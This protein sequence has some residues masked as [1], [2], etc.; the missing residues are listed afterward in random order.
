MEQQSTRGILVA[1]A[2]VLAAACGSESSDPQADANDVGAIAGAGGNDTTPTD[3]TA[4]PGP[5]APATGGTA[6]SPSVAPTSAPSTSSTFAGTCV[7]VTCTAPPLGTPGCCTAPGTG[8]PGNVLETAGRA[9]DMCGTDLGVFVPTLTGVCV[10][11]DQ[12]GD[13]DGACPTVSNGF[14]DE[15]GCCTDEGFC[16][17]T[18]AS[19]GLGCHYPVSGR[20]PTCGL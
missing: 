11:M 1:V 12:P 13:P 19:A 4:G 3:A 6:G 9:P 17:T 20:G 2:V 16:G 5:A 8:E 18:S 15:P 10:Q 7:G 14:A